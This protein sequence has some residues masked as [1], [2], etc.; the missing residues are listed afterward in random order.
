MHSLYVDDLLDCDYVAG[1]RDVPRIDCWGLVRI[2]YERIHGIELPLLDTMRV[3][4]VRANTL[5]YRDMHSHV[6]E[7]DAR[8]GAIIAVFTGRLCT[9]VAIVIDIDGTLYAFE[10]TES[11]GVRA[12]KLTE[13]EALNDRTKYYTYA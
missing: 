1:G 6:D 12:V 10:M 9:H 13:Y 5:A 3:G 8:H 7:I 11:A 2:V 4:S